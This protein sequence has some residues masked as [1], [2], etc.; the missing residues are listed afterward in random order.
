MVCV[1]PDPVWPY[2]STVTLNPRHSG[3]YVKFQ[4]IEVNRRDTPNA[5]TILAGCTTNQ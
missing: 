5:V 2:A 3:K 4:K 1:L